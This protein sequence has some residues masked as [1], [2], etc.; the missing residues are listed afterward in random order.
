[1]VPVSTLTTSLPGAEMLPEACTVIASPVSSVLVPSSGPST[2]KAAGRGTA[3][4][5][6]AARAPPLL[7]PSQA[8]TT[9]MAA[10]LT[11]RVATMACKT[12]MSVPSRDRLLWSP[13]ADRFVPMDRDSG[14]LT[15]L[16][17]DVISL[18]RL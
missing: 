1:S 5:P 16:R 4:D 7:L 2:L 17:V 18:I 11:D 10:A 12:C 9:S 3:Q 13:L 15:V 8:P 6:V 14:L